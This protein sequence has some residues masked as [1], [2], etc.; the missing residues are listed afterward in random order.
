MPSIAKKPTAI[1]V[2]NIIL[3]W[4]NNDGELVTNLKM[5]K[6]LYYAQA[7]HLVNFNKPLFEESIEAWQLGPVVRSAY[8]VFKKYG[9]GPI[10]YKDEGGKEAE[11]FTS[12][13][14]EFLKQF[15]DVYI[16]LKAH[17]LVNMTH[18][19]DPWK[20]AF[21]LGVTIDEKEMKDFYTVLYREQKQTSKV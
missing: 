15:Y 20:T 18:N 19:E 17:E 13:Q 1:S 2:A 11:V 16:R 4:A 7:W 10:K 21:K 3:H 9:N 5:Q 6:L 8:D 12:Q 14:R